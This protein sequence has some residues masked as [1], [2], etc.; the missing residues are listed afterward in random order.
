MAARAV[1][2]PIDTTGTL[3]ELLTMVS[4]TL[5]SLVIRFPNPTKIGTT[6]APIPAFVV[7]VPMTV[8]TK[9]GASWLAKELSLNVASNVVNDGNSLTRKSV[10]AMAT[11]LRPRVEPIVRDCVPAI[12][13]IVAS[14][15]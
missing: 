7:A 13:T 14:P 6:L 11:P 10:P 15:K 12:A 1:A 4:P 3:I 9:A 5:I 2:V 8:F